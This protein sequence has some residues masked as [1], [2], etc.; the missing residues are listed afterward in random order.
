M[1]CCGRG[2]KGEGGAS[3]LLGDEDKEAESERNNRKRD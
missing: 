2:E 1:K 3:P